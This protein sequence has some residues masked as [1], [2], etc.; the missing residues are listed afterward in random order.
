VTVIG[1][2]VPM[3]TIFE[4]QNVAYTYLGKFEALK[5][6]NLTIDCG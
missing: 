6:V 3:E 5:D 1:L 4:L 2:D